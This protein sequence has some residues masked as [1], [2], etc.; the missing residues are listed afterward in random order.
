MVQQLPCA[1]DRANRLDKRFEKSDRRALRAFTYQ[2]SAATE[3]MDVRPGS[4]HGKGAAAASSSRPRKRCPV[5]LRSD[6][7][8]I[9]LESRTHGA[10]GQ[11]IPRRVASPD[12][13]CFDGLD[14]LFNFRFPGPLLR[15]QKRVPA[16]S[17]TR[18]RCDNA[19]PSRQSSGRTCNALATSVIL[20]SFPGYSRFRSSGGR[21]DARK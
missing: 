3:G 16:D 5:Q 2:L 12:R 10:G 13:P 9:Y 15:Q 21:D 4:C 7:S 19:R 6:S 20:H 14:A 11:R 1:G 18:S 8:T 17:N